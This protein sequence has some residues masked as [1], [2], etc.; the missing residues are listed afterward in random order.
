[1]LA[2]GGG[3][4]V[5][6]LLALIGTSI[7]RAIGSSI[8]IVLLGSIPAILIH[9][10]LGH[11]DWML[12]LFLSIGAIPASYVGACITVKM[13]KDRLRILYGLFILVF[14]IYFAIFEIVNM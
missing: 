14:S 1:M 13:D 12:T 9:A 7:K 5:V 3:I 10:Y 6:P 8:A 4:L 11:I 2:N